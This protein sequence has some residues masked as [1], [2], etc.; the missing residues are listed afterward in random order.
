MTIINHFDYADYAKSKALRSKYGRFMGQFQH[1]S[2]EI[3]ERNMK[4]VREGKYDLKTKNFNVFGDAQG[5]AK[6]NRMAWIYFIVPIIAGSYM[7]LD[8]S[9]LIENDTVSRLDQLKVAL[10]GD[11]DEIEQAF[12]GKGPLLATFGGPL[13]SDLIEIGMMMELINIEDD[14][15]WTLFHGLE[16]RD[17]TKSSTDM[18]RKLRIQ[19]LILNMIFLGRRQG[20]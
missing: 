11:D 18:S 17:P 5:L 12:Y 6:V 16:R 10:T 1:Y 4:I 14:D 3:M 13:L 20:A 2:F 19:N 7:G 15:V 9:N 8:F